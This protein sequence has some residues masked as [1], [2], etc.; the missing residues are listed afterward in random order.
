MSKLHTFVTTLKLR[1]KIFQRTQLRS[2]TLILK[3]LLKSIFSSEF[4]LGF[5]SLVVSA[6][7]L[8]VARIQTE[9]SALSLYPHFEIR[10]QGIDTNNDQINDTSVIT[11]NNR[12]GNFYAFNCETASFVII[13]DLRDMSSIKE[14]FIPID[15]MYDIG[16]RSSTPPLIYEKH[17]DRY[18]DI[19][20]STQEL[21]TENCYHFG[22][23]T[24]LKITYQNIELET[25]VEYYNSNTGYRLSPEEGAYY[26]EKY[27]IPSLI[28][29]DAYFDYR[30]SADDS[31]DIIL[32]CIDSILTS[33]KEI[34]SL[35]LIPPYEK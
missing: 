10:H 1:T 21:M 17:C 22:I 16:Y 6:C 18:L 14:H 19:A 8:H 7:S 13:R 2:L 27:E 24:L 4:F 11:I 20:S 9:L 3:K 26:F 23:S 29:D 33:E 32:N 12:G 34:A 30:P 35:L 25:I 5:M 15:M 31:I 28:D